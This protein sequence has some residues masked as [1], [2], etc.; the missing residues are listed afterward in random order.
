VA[1]PRAQQGVGRRL[2]A[3]TLLG[4]LVPAAC[5]FSLLAPR[6]FAAAPNDPGFPYQWSDSNTGQSIPTQSAVGEEPLGPPASGT[7]GADDRALAAWATST[8]SRSIVIGVLDSGAQLS[9]PDLA[10]N[11]WTNP[12]GVGGCEKGTHGFDAVTSTCYPEDEDESYGGHGTHVAGI[13]GAVGNNGVGVAGLNW[14]TSILPVKWVQSAGAETDDLVDALKWLVAAKEQ[15]AN[16]RVVNDSLTFFGTLPSPE[17]KSEIEALG[18]HDILFVTAAG[19]T[20]NNNDKESV[21]RYPCGYGLANEICV[22][23]INNQDELPPWANYGA[24]TVDLAA[25]GVSI[26]STLRGSRYGYLSGGSMASAEVSAAAALILSVE[27]TMTAPEVKA[28][29]L[30]SVRPLPALKGQVTSGGTLDVCR[31]LP[32]CEL[33]PRPTV[34]T[35]EASSI[36]QTS[37]TLNARVNPNGAEVGD[38]HFDYGSTS[39]Y[40]QAVRCVPM[41]GT[42]TRPVQVTA[43]VSALSPNTPY[44]FRVA[45]SNAGGASAGSDASFTTLPDPPLVGAASA[46][47]ITQTSAALNATVNPNG[48]FV[49]DCHFEFGKTAAYGESAQCARTPGNGAVAV[50]VSASLGPLSPNTAYH[51]RVVASNLGGASRSADATFTTPPDAPGVVSQAPSAIAQSTATVNGLVDPEGASV[52]SCEFE[53]GATTAYGASVP[54]AALPG[55]GESLEPVSASLTELTPDTTYHFRLVASNSGGTTHG[56]DRTLTTL[57]NAPGAATEAA[58]SV[59]QT[60]AV[61]NATVNPNRGTV[62]S[63]RFE[64]GPTASYGHGVPCASLPGSG[65]NPAAVFAS[66]GGLAAN[67]TYHFRIVATN[68]GGT[69]DGA[70][71]TFTSLPYSPSVLTGAAS[72]V[73][74]D[75]ATLNATVDPKGAAI[76]DCHFEFGPTSALGSSAACSSL[77]SSGNE[78]VPVSVRIGALSPR[79]TYHFRIVAVNAGGRSEGSEQT[80][81][82]NGQPIVITEA[83]TAVTQNSARLNGSVNPDGAE[84]SE[85]RFDYGA[86]AA[87]GERAPCTPWPPVGSSAVEVS[88]ALVGLSSGRPYHFRVV[89]TNPEGT[90][91]GAD[92]TFTTPAGAGREPA[93]GVPPPASGGQGPSLTSLVQA[94]P[95]ISPPRLPPFPTL[96]S[97]V[98][99]QSPSGSVRVILACPPGG[100]TCA[101]AILVRIVAGTQHGKDNARGLRRRGA[102]RAPIVASGRY[103]AAAGTDVSATLAVSSVGQRLLAVAHRLRAEAVLLESGLA[104]VGVSEDVPVTLLGATAPVKAKHR[105]G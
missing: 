27:P 104:R 10:A 83:A 84:V 74:G 8:G 41:P 14:N 88:A 6:A 25:P 103:S 62:T 80:F 94:G 13:M 18:K 81:T 92:Q 54:C 16:I 39:A 30:S 98:F 11:L 47:S 78:P 36:T 99:K 56:A 37:V 79:T 2:A 34:T 23:A 24:H 9:H 28:D 72:E 63:C 58:S 57:P 76:S 38:C 26:Y 101:G 66:I 51:F 75:A 3:A 77:P 44:H 89:A 86:T 33:P 49:T 52:S 50:A 73:E 17:V 105:G 67:T 93:P 64:Y 69:S 31:A 35:L 29:I 59:T 95:A 70:D 15:G 85:C 40:G 82:T 32:G 21:R 20:G 60:S 4:A 65:E 91:V 55:S 22:T 68:A 96:L 45:A 71:A 97:R 102:A 43:T 48:A 100:G 90:S 1:S 7:P 19:N 61:L 53:Y 5:A 46:S 42:G 12:G 87:Y